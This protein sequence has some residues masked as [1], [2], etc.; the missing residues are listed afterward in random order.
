MALYGPVR[1][2][3]NIIWTSEALVHINN[4]FFGDGPVHILPYDPQCHELFAIYAQTRVIIFFT[5]CRI[6]Y[7]I[8]CQ[9]L[10]IITWQHLSPHPPSGHPLSTSLYESMVSLVAMSRIDKHIVDQKLTFFISKIREILCLDPHERTF[11]ATLCVV[12]S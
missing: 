9:I 6:K 7:Y 10:L 11:W 1:H 3:K 2:Q 8:V 4:I 12:S 5:L